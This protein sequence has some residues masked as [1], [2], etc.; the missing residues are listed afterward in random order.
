MPSLYIANCSKAEFFFTYMLPENMRPFSQHIRAGAQIEIKGEQPM[1]DA[2]ISQHEIYGMQPAEK[3]TRRFG[4]LAYRLNKPISVEAIQQ[5][6]TQSE[7]EQI[8]RA[9]EARK[10]TTVAQDQMFA[11]KAQEVGSKQTAP[12]EIEI[13]E[14]TRGPADT[15]P[16][17]NQTLVVE[18]EGQQD[19]G[20]RGRGRKS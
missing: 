13:S 19:Q 7:Q 16:K 17:F 6:L 3:V 18:R 11:N 5:G 2:I 1:L 12:L 14:E 10:I 15:S 8:E 4:G 9:L 20:K